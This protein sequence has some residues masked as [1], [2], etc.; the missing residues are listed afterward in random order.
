[1]AA[2]K[3]LKA[4]TRFGCFGRLDFQIMKFR[5]KRSRRWNLLWVLIG[6]AA[7][8]PAFAQF[9]DDFRL[10]QEFMIKEFKQGDWQ[11]Y[12]WGELRLV[13]DASRLG[14]WFVQQ[15][16]LYEAA[17][18][19]QLGLGGSWIEVQNAESSWTTLARFEVEVTPKWKW[20]GGWTGSLRNR[21][22]GRHWE[23]RDWDL[24]WV[25]RH[26]L[27]LARPLE[28]A[29]PLERYEFSNELF[30]DYRI[31]RLNENRFR[32]LNLHFRASSWS[33]VNLFI[34]VRSR[35]LGEDR[36]W[37]HSTMAGVGFRVSLY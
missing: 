9:E 2:G 25:T 26:R 37:V 13:D 11:G 18:G 14:T 35:R 7:P 4:S 31:G 16:F 1:M 20:D 23:S 24:E 17:P 10:W 5:G 28:S 29:G 34:Q 30:M 22:E 33:T 27:L 12:T 3:E 21:L 19:W 32:P 15:K 8:L 6:L 36:R